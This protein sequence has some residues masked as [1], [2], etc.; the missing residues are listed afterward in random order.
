MNPISAFQ[1]VRISAFYRM[2]AF[3]YL[4]I[5]AFYRMSEI[6]SR[7]RRKINTAQNPEPNHGADGGAGDPKGGR[8]PSLLE[9]GTGFHPELIDR[10]NVFLDGA[11]LADR[12]CWSVWFPDDKS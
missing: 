8:V 11:I 1:N 2:S 9:V 3:Q 7:R 5:S 4:S 12:A 6:A 10:E